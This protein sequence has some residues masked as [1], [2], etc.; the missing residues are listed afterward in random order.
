MSPTVEIVSAGNHV[1]GYFLYFL[2]RRHGRRSMINKEQASSTSAAMHLLKPHLYS[3]KY[4]GWGVS[5]VCC[6]R[7]RDNI[8]RVKGTMLEEGEVER[9]HWAYFSI[10]FFSESRT[11]PFVKLLSV[12]VGHCVVPFSIGGVIAILV[13]V[14]ERLTR[15]RFNN[16]AFKDAIFASNPD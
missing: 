15:I 3:M 6:I 9:W 1:A 12:L 5:Y 7:D 14:V 16:C 2:N 4:I 8:W 13:N 11:E 10:C